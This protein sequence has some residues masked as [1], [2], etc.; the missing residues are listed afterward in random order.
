MSNYYGMNKIPLADRG[1]PFFILH[2]DFE[3]FYIYLPA[4]FRQQA[5]YLGFFL[6]IIFGYNKLLEGE[7]K[8]SL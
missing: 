8:E 7:K 3:S 6:G 5:Q 1:E 4:F 2:F